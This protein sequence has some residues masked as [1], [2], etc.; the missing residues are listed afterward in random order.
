MRNAVKTGIFD[1]DGHEILV[2]DTVESDRGYVGKVMFGTY[3]NDHYGVYIEWIKTPG[4]DKS[5]LRQNILFWASRVH[6]TR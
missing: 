6:V 1:M 3:A 4:V 5:Y 2:G